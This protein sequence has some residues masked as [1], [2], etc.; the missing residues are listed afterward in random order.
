MRYFIGNLIRGEV[1]EYY[2]ATCADLASRFG[3]EDVSAIVGPHITV[4]SPF[5][6]HE[7]VTIDDTLALISDAPAIPISLSKWGHFGNRTIFLDVVEPPVALKDFMRNV[8]S[9][10]RANGI[11]LGPQE[12]NPHIHMSIARF[13]KPLQYE[14]VWKYL[15][16]TPAPKFDIK[17]DN[18]TIFCK[19]NIDDKAW[20]VLKTFPLMGK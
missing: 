13:L 9:K 5:D 20:K 19:E 6:R 15:E 16:A 17:F 8:L 12:S 10:L 2:K 11:F 14:E 4:K 1:A 7:I 3:I 18:L